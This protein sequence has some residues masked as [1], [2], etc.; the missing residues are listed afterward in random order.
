MPYKSRISSGHS[1]FTMLPYNFYQMSHNNYRK[2]VK[3]Y[4]ASR[5]IKA[6]LQIENL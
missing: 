4:E 1:I 5:L 6:A 3:I 2:S